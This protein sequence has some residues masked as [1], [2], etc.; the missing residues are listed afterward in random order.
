MKHLSLGRPVEMSFEPKYVCKVC[1]EKLYTRRSPKTKWQEWLYTKDGR[2][3]FKNKCN[4]ATK[5]K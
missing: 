1:G 4:L 5:N 2:R 3:H